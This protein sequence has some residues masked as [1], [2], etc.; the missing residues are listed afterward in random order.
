MPITVSMERTK[1]DDGQEWCITFI[2]NGKPFYLKWVKIPRNEPI[3]R[4]I[5][6]RKWARGLIL[7]HTPSTYHI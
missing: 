7:G 1:A 5:L 2:D 6:L 3:K 4:L